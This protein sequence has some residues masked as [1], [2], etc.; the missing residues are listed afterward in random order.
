[1]SQEQKM[2]CL[3]EENA[4]LKEQISRLIEFYNSVEIHSK[5]YEADQRKYQEK[6][7]SSSN[8][9]GAWRWLFHQK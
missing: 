7:I 6:T 9:W 2:K 4:K 1:M 5:G 8:G 3:E